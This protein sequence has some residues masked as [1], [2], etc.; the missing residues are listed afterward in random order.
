MPH[1]SLYDEFS[2]RVQGDVEYIKAMVNKRNSGVP[3]SIKEYNKSK[4]RLLS[5]K[6]R[7]P[8][9]VER[10]AI[11]REHLRHKLELRKN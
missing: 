9:G 6:N 3:I 11:L 1:I 2:D 4:E 5:L 8:H 10:T 7:K